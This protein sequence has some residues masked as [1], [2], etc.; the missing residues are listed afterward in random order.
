MKKLHC[1]I[2]CLT[3]TISF[4]NAQKLLPVGFHSGITVAQSSN[5]Y[6][7]QVE[8]GLSY[9]LTV[10]QQG[11]DVVLS[12][13]DKDSSLIIEVDSPTGS[14]GD[15]EILYKA[16]RSAVLQLTISP[17]EDQEEYSNGY[18][19]IWLSE[20]DKNTLKARKKDQRRITKE[21]RSTVQTLD[22]THFWEAY[23]ELANVST[24]ADSIEVIQ[25]LYIDRATEGFKEF[26]LVR[27]EMNAPN[28]VQ[29]LRMFP[30]FYASLRANTSY[31]FDAKKDVN[32]VFD[33]FNS[34]YDDFKPFRVCF[35]IGVLS[36]GGTVTN[37]YVLIGADLTCSTASLD[38]SEFS[39]APFNQLLPHLNYAGDINQKIRNIVAHECVHTQ[40]PDDL[41]DSEQTCSLL[42]AC[43][44]EGFCD[45]VGEYL[46]GE[47]INASLQAYGDAH[48][49]AIWKSFSSALCNGSQ[50]DWLYNYGRFEDKPADL[51]YYIGYVVAKKFF[52]LAEDKKEAIRLLIDFRDA[53]KILNASK[54][55]EKW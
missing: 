18:V 12:L 14:F 23:D 10:L 52:D 38:L 29:A 4:V 40:Q 35:A 34:V 5:H 44:S 45:F 39:H 32:F 54:Y 11:I 47:Q 8:E 41:D 27:P 33:R 3:W 6:S 36:T 49:E 2:A 17:F 46:V 43:L 37:D 22:I 30:K 16:K 48:E 20:M 55:Q 51:G 24:S 25:R 50:E 15:E 31:V 1:F 19:D 21:N 28:Y 13:Y 9:K 42:H 7:L 26:M 53:E